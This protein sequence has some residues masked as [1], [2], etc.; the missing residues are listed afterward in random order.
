MTASVH[1]FIKVVV[2]F[3]RRP[4]GGLRAYSDDVP[5]LM[6]AGP[7]PEAVFNDVIPA[8]EELFHHNQNMDVKFGP[9]TRV[10]AQLQEDGL[11][12]KSDREDREYAAQ[13]SDAA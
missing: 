3:E 6:L 7:N 5:G 9:V 12:P 4:D 10:R 13:V 1:R 8:L 11:L 2:T